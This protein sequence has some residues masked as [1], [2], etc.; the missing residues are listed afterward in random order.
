MLHLRVLLCLLLLCERPIEVLLEGINPLRLWY[1]VL[2]LLLRGL[3]LLLRLTLGALLVVLLLLSEKA[4]FE[5]ARQLGEL[6]HD[7]EELDGPMLRVVLERSLFRVEEVIQRLSVHFG[8]LGSLAGVVPTVSQR[9]RARCCLTTR[10]EERHPL[11]ADLVVRQKDELPG[12]LLADS[13]LRE[14]A[15]EDIN[16]LIGVVL[17]LQHSEPV[18][19]EIVQRNSLQGK[20]KVWFHRRK[21]QRELFSFKL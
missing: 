18:Q 1:L 20:G 10:E 8:L 6:T 13:V 21:V 19:E 17:S 3:R 5:V 14:T 16:Y 7:A 12:V 15:A 2:L 11:C 4:L 9:F